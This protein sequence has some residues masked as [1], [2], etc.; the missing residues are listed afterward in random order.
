MQKT[1]AKTV[2]AQGRHTETSSR[3]PGVLWMAALFLAV[4]VAY[5]NHFDNDFHFDDTH[6]VV[7]NPA[8]RSIA[9][10]PGFFTDATSFSVDPAH[11]TYRPLVTASLAIDYA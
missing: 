6:A 11:Q 9:N 1:R 10:I 4:F 2:Q 7:N 5:A 8:I 3:A